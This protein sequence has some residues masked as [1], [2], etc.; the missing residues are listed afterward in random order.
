MSTSNLEQ[1]RAV[2]DQISSFFKR[3]E[4]E[5]IRE[6]IARIQFH[7]NEAKKLSLE[8]M[9]LMGQRE[10]ESLKLCSDL[11]SLTVGPAAEI[12]KQEAENPTFKEN[13]EKELAKIAEEAKSLA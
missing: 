11:A 3:S 4:N 9:K 7:Q 12:L 5:D 13:L 6:L 2:A 8:V 1:A 10:G